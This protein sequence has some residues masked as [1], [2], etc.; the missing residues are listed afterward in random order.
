MI[1]FEHLTECDLEDMGYVPEVPA[2]RADDC[3]DDADQP[4]TEISSGLS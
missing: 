4:Q 1:T 3:G 2:E